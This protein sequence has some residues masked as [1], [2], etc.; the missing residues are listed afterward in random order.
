MKR[1]Y[2]ILILLLFSAALSGCDA[3]TASQQASAAKAQAK[4]AE[5]NAQVQIAHAQ[6]TETQAIQTTA[7]VAQVE[8]SNRLMA[9]LGTLTVIAQNP[10]GYIVMIVITGMLFVFGLVAITLTERRHR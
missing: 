4:A 8:A 1:L 9:F 6:A 5:A 7:Q 10:T 2:L 3:I